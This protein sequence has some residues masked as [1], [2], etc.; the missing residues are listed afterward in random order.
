MQYNRMNKDA[1]D[2][3]HRTGNK[4]SNSL[5]DLGTYN[6]AAFAHHSRP[7]VPIGRSTSHYKLGAQA[8]LSTV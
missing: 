2:E 1:E 5:I 6:W 8:S 7:L 4:Y 3:P